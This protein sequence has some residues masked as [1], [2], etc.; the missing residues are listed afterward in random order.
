M[1]DVPLSVKFPGGAYVGFNAGVDRRAAEQLVMVCGQ[2]I[3][4]G[5]SEITLCMTSVGGLLEHAYYAYGILDALPLKITT[6]NLGSVQSAANMLF[7]CGD[8][9]YAMEGSTFF[10][11]KSSFNASEGQVLTEAFITERLKAI[12]YE[13]NRSAAILAAKTGRSVEEVRE[14]Q[15]AEA[16]MN[17]DMAIKNGLIHGVK[18]LSVPK[19]AYFH[20][21]VI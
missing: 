12:Q 17:T 16:V 15:N 11:H 1:T 19:D 10:F 20:Q 7:L 18:P 8:Q 4:Q 13:D 14:W 5:Y 2:A 6:H 9:R 21:V 3:A